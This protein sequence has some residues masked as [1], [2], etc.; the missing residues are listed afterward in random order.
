MWLS[1][2]HLNGALSRL[3]DR[4]KPKSK[5]WVLGEIPLFWVLQQAN[6]LLVCTQHRAA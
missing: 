4:V 5:Y 6:E 3:V 1:P 2:K